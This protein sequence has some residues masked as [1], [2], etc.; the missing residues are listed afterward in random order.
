[1]APEQLEQAA[2][3]HTRLGELDDGPSR[4]AAQAGFDA[5]HSASDEH[6]FAY[7]AIVEADGIARACAD[8]PV[9]HDLGEAALARAAVRRRHRRYIAVV[10]LVGAIVVMPVAALGISHFMQPPAPEVTAAPVRV[11]STGIGERSSFAI[12]GPARVMLDTTS[13]A[14]VAGTTL[15]VW[16]QAYVSTPGEPIRLRVPG[17]VIRL[18]LGGL[19]VRTT[20]T[21]LSVFA[22][23][24]PLNAE[25]ERATGGSVRLQP[26]RSLGLANDRA[27]VTAPADAAAITGWR[28]GWLLFD[29][30]PLGNAVAEVNRYRRVPIRVSPDVSDWR[31]SGSFRTDQSAGFLDTVATSLPVAIARS[32]GAPTI[33]ARRSEN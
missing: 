18:R 13:R 24:A 9:L 27:R 10:G 21:G 4:S 1:M 20:G 32:G 33:S 26:G 14:T 2:W 16:G 25:Y 12:A 19:N 7:A 31:I 8:E 11:F 23:D 5:W 6:R 29:D 22:D 28:D 30:V 17:G 15:T 3:W